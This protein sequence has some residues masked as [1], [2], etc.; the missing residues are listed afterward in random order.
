[1]N[2]L[3][4]NELSEAKKRIENLFTKAKAELQTEKEKLNKLSVQLK[5]EYADVQRLEEGS[6]T[7]MFY[8]FLGSKEKKLDKERQEYLAAKLKF[9]SCKK[10]IQEL[11]C[12]IEKLQ[13]VA[14]LWFSRVGIQAN[15]SRQEI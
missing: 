15:F 7:A 12:E 4:L 10:E 1:M 13:N 9:K 8:E 2:I 3:K 5:K 14:E 6:L 11:G